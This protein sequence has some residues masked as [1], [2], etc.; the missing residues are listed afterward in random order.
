M[1]VGLSALAVAVSMLAFVH[2]WPVS[3][4]SAKPAIRSERAGRRHVTAANEERF[5]A[6]ELI[7]FGRM[8]FLA[9]W[10]DQYS[11]DLMPASRAAAPQEGT[12][13]RFIKALATTAAMN[14]PPVPE[15]HSC[16][17]CH[18]RPN[19]TPGGRG[20]SA[21]ATGAGVRNLRVPPVPSLWP[22]QGG[23][24]QRESR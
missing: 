15:A 24:G 23:G 5:G 16:A 18:N 14:R 13:P 17:D 3:L 8:M 12:R 21:E 19:D 2:H 22:R 4:L 1:R 6:A 7:E 20:V 11:V 9:D 10:T